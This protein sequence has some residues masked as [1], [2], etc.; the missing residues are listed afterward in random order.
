MGFKQTIVESNFRLF[1]VKLNGN[2]KANKKEKV[3]MHHC[4]KLLKED[5]HVQIT[6]CYKEVTRYV[7][8]LAS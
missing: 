7:D 2:D 3:L 6:H 1:V 5:W 8:Y 4:M